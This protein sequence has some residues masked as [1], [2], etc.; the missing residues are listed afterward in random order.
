[1][2]RIISA[3]KDTY[4]TN[5]I[6]NNKFRATDANLG[7][8]GTLDLFKLYAENIS[9][10]DT[11]P[12]EFSRLLIKFDLSEAITMNSN[13]VIDVG[14]S[15]FKAELNL[16]DIYGGQTTPNDFNIIVC[17]DKTIYHYIPEVM[18]YSEELA[19]LPIPQKVD[20]YRYYLLEKYGGAWVD[21][22][23]ICLK[24]LC[25]V[26]KKLKDYEYVGVGNGYS[27]KLG[28]ESMHSPEFIDI[29][30]VKQRIVLDKAIEMGYYSRPRGCTQREIASV[31]NIKQATVSEHLQSAESKIINSIG[32]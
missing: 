20:I 21:A 13:K 23:T 3:S 22:D 28:A 12:T 5:K 11:K 15:T 27:V 25:P 17:N 1:M 7:Q 19:K 29:L 24:C 2:Y 18:Q 9:G 31:M 6:V 4:I 14:D 30:P 26:Y 10:S 8:A 32:K 16:H